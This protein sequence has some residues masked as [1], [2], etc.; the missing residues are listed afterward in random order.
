M[1]IARDE[2]RC[3]TVA[4]VGDAGIGKTRLSES[5]AANPNSRRPQ[6]CRRIVTSSSRIRHS[7]LISYLWA[8]IGLTLED[9]VGVRLQKIS[10]YLDELAENTP[11]NNNSSQVF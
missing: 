4:V 9:E 5:F 8:R 6:F 11:E 3:Q 10:T 7:I 1:R 2:R